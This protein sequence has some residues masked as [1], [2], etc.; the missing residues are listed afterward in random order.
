MK[1]ISALEKAYKDDGAALLAV[2]RRYVCDEQT[3]QD[4]LQDGFVTA[5][6]NFDKF[7]DRGKGSLKAWLSKIMVNTCL[8]YLRKN[9]L[10]KESREITEAEYRLV[11]P[12]GLAGMVSGMDSGTL[13][14]L[15]SGLPPDERTV[16]NLA[17]F[18]EFSHKE[19]SKMLGISES[20][21]AT[22]LHRAKKHLAEKIEQY[23][24]R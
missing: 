20:N 23:E 12:G 24:K 19:I 16:L 10:L 5:W 1:D 17:V 11:A 14:N 9:D 8:M 2:C 18:E 3:A 22:R 13:H 6:C 21:S 7:E 15:V 4:M